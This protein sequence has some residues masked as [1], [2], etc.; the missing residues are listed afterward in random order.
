MQG[1]SQPGRGSLGPSR[2]PHLPL[3]PSPWQA[4]GKD[5][6]PTHLLPGA[7]GEGKVASG[8][9]G[10]SG[11]KVCVGGVGGGK[12]G[13]RRGRR[14]GRRRGREGRGSGNGAHPWTPSLHPPPPPS[15]PPP[16]PR[17]PTRRTTTPT[18]AAAARSLPSTRCGRTSSWWRR[19]RVLGAEGGRREG[20][21]LPRGGCHD[22]PAA[23]T[24]AEPAGPASQPRGPTDLAASLI[25][26][27]A[28]P[29]VRP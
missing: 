10:M 4:S 23:P 5:L 11:I 12:V 9:K 2:A 13:F 26:R 29:H 8:L 16:R 17:S 7:D 27:A 15:T 3:A 28:R 21:C 14:G 19:V 25:V 18:R 1:C 22:R 6:L 24:R 20:T